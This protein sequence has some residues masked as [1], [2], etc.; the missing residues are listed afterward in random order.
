MKNLPERTVVFV[1]GGLAAAFAARQLARAGIDTLVLERGGEPGAGAESRIP[2]QRDELRWAVRG[3][4]V[5]DPAAETYTLRR[6]R[7]EPARPMRRLAA[8]LPGTGAGGAGNH[9]NGES[10][11]WRG[12]NLALRSRLLDRY[13]RGAIPADMPLQDWGVAHA[14]LEPYY[15]L[16]ERLF[17]VS[18]RA[19]NLRG[20]VQPGGNPFED[21]REHEYPQPPLESTE[22]GL[23]FQAAARERG[24]HP[25]PMPAANSSGTYVNPDG[26]ALGACQYCGHCARY[27][28]EASA[29]GTPGTLLYPWLRNQPCFELRPHAHVLALEPDAAAGRVRA[30]RYLDLL[31]GEE[32]RQPAAVVVLSA[33]TFTTVRLLLSAGI[34]RAY[35][36][37]AGTGTLG[38]NLCL[39]TT[40]GLSLFYRDRW[41]N[42][43]L[44]AGAA[45]TLIDEFTDDNFDHAGLGFL[46]GGSMGVGLSSG[47]PIQ[48]RR[49]PP[50]TPRWGTAWKQAA[51]DWY[52]HSFGLGVQGSCYP[53]R[54]NFLDLDPDYT[55]AFGQPLL[56]L[57]FDFRDNELR[58]SA[59]C[60]A[61]AA[62]IA[63]AMGATH[64]GPAAPRGRPFDVRQYVGT[65]VTGGTIMGADPAT[66]VVS[67]R[68]Q[69]W[70]AENLF[71][72]SSSVF[73]HNA[74][75]NPSELLGALALRLGDD[76][77]RYVARPGRLPAG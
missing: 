65:H 25:Y 43:F 59:Y 76:L 69:H 53:H 73:A 71:V 9:W 21:P 13:G 3:G 38:R 18:G 26:M 31:T 22:A 67:P 50:G 4:L 48:A 5:Q 44:A 1:G 42:P 24:Y 15:D 17:G 68:L 41:I 45:G 47:A 66:S 10:H 52:N 23:I 74:G 29:K 35:D 39:Q 33:F 77:V 57:T 63:R 8:F 56:R 62:E 51:A 60:T 32:C 30:V 19:G 6:S 14:E 36:P 7:T 72:A 2:S 37:A 61:R 70:D 54:E 16:F 58:M 20:R 49:L 64:V 12:Y 55:D 75:L 11:R 28:C 27:L 34:G 40:S 46:G